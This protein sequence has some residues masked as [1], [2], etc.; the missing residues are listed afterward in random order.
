MAYR[1]AK[2]NLSGS[3]G[4][5]PLLRLPDVDRRAIGTAPFQPLL[6]FDG[7]YQLFVALNDNGTLYW[8]SPA[9]GDSF[10]CARLE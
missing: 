4:D 5:F 9:S 7:N 6:S 8:F 10:T 3:L 2:N 1:R